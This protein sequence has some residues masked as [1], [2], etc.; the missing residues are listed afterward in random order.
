[1]SSLRRAIIAGLVTFAM[2]VLIIGGPL[3]ARA[4]HVGGSDNV[5][6]HVLDRSSR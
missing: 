5:T 1:M 4:A 6:H 3:A 2:P